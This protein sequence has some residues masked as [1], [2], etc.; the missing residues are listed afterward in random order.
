MLSTIVAA[1]KALI[2][3][4]LA[5][6][7]RKP[8]LPVPKESEQLALPMPDVPHVD[9]L[10]V[11]PKVDVPFDL[12]PEHV[13]MIEDTDKTTTYAILQGEPM[14]TKQLVFF[15]GME[16][17]SAK[18]L[19]ALDDTAKWIGIETDWLDAA[20]AF[21]TANTFSVSKPNAAGSGAMGLIQFMPETSVNIGIIK[22]GPKPPTSQPDARK[23]WY[24]DIKVR[25]QAALSKMTFQEQLGWVRKY[26]LP[27][28]G[29]LKSLEDVYLTIF[30]PIEIGRAPTD[31]IAYTGDPV[32]TQN[33]GFDRGEKGFITRGDVTATIVNKLHGAIATGQQIAVPVALGTGIA[34]AMG[35]AAYG[36]YHLAK[37]GPE[38]TA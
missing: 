14:A 29:K 35:A 15:K 20:I 10:G 2:A 5:I 38:A 17:L 27:N 13:E 26:F 7:I 34:L 11:A 31:I 19:R 28:R 22:A 37:G 16:H 32:Y 33:A 23:A 21:E 8:A 30:Y 36:L 1:V 6:F 4:L 9:N 25:S 3:K 12:E 18:D 24:A